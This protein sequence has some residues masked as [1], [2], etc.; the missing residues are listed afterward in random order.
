[1]TDH[2]HSGPESYMHNPGIVSSAARPAEEKDD[3]APSPS[4]KRRPVTPLPAIP[5]EN[6]R[7][8]FGLDLGERTQMSPD[9]MGAKGLLDEE[10]SFPDVKDII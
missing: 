1:M 5:T 2:K 7:A 3:R 4:V 9:A 8:V 6:G 10:T